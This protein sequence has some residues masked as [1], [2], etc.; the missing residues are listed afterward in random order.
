MLGNYEVLSFLLYQQTEVKLKKKQKTNVNIAMI[1]DNS[2]KLI[3]CF[4]PILTNFENEVFSSNLNI[5][6]KYH[7][8]IKVLWIKI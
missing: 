4:W 7:P 6:A 1:H 2:S 3:P 5:S 8:S